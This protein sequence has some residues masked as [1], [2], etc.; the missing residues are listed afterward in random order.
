M[1]E[2][3]TS[4][5]QAKKY[6]GTYLDTDVYTL[7]DLK[8]LRESNFGA[9]AARTEAYD[10]LNSGQWMTEPNGKVIS[11]WQEEMHK[12][13][14][15]TPYG[16]DGW[17]RAS[18]V[19][20]RKVAHELFGEA[21][22][23]ILIL[24]ERAF[25]PGRIGHNGDPFFGAIPALYGWNSEHPNPAG[26]FTNDLTNFTQGDSLPDFEA[27]EANGERPPW[28]EDWSTSYLFHAFM[29]HEE[30]LKS[31]YISTWTGG[32]YQRLTPRYV[33]ER[34]TRFARA[35]YPV[36]KHMYDT[37]VLHVDDFDMDKEK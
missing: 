10:H 8:P 26:V 34:Q 5:L 15:G 35:L 7:Q 30:P 21:G 18:D 28:S 1:N 3:L 31:E 17:A 2:P 9:V 11:A 4:S 25:T 36:A 24:E 14:V 29:A 19:A 16:T 22:G 13:F 23:H 32:R 33:L 37:G 27:A 12:V 6:G 20:F